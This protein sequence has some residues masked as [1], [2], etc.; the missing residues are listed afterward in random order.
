MTVSVARGRQAGLTTV[1]V[2]GELD[3]AA[4]DIVARAIGQEIAAPGTQAVSVDLSEAQFLDSC[5]ISIPLKGRREADQAGAAYRI[6]EATG[7]VRH[8]LTLT[9]ILEHLGAEPSTDSPG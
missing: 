7:I 9:G 6:T 5:G 3:L 2:V 8:I 4:A 1:T